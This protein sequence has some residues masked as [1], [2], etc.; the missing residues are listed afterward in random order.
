ME[1][2]ESLFGLALADQLPDSYGLL[3]RC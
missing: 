1:K 2:Y 3:F